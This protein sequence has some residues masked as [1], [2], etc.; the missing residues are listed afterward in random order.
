MLVSKPPQRGR[1]PLYR[2][3]VTDHHKLLGVSSA[4][5]YAKMAIV[6]WEISSRVLVIAVSARRTNPVERSLNRDPPAPQSDP[7]SELVG[8]FEFPRI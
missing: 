4:A 5:P 3:P 7:L 2:L 8:L 6:I 1:G